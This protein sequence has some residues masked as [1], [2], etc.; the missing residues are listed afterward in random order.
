[1][2]WT[3]NTTDFLISPKKTDSFFFALELL[4]DDIKPGAEVLVAYTN[5]SSKFVCK[6]TALSATPTPASC[7]PIQATVTQIQLQFPGAFPS[8]ASKI[9]LRDV[10]IYELTGASIQLATSEYPD[11][12]TGN[13]VYIPVT[14]LAEYPVKRSVIL[15]DGQGVPHIATVDTAAITGA[16]LVIRFTPALPR[17]FAA[18]ATMMFGNVAKATHG[19]TVKN[20]VLG[21][22]DASARL[23]KFQLKK[24]PV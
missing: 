17:P 9:D 18:D 8:G 23:Q 7:G 19:E 4:V 22:G 15:D 16:H 20:E 21:N 10:T 3:I 14:S 1:I 6:G 12:I 2:R 5:S 13:G 11:T 24:S